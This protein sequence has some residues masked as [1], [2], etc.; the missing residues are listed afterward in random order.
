MEILIAL[1]AMI[2]LSE[3]REW[4][5]GRKHRHLELL[6]KALRRQVEAL[7]DK[8]EQAAEKGA[9][10]TEFAERAATELATLNRAID[11][12]GVRIN[13]NPSKQAEPDFIEGL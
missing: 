5:A 10:A 1:A 6:V 4:R 2:A 9:A 8:L 13:Y 11:A 7:P 12:H 3:L